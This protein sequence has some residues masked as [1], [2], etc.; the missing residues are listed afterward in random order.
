MVRG[1]TEGAEYT[2]ACASSFA[3]GYGGHAGFLTANFANG[4]NGLCSGGEILTTQASPK[5]T[6][7]KRKYTKREMG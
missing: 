3:K 5:A 2:E 7:G 4:A 6:P 1:T